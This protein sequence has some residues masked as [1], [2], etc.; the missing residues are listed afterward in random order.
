MNRF[1][2]FWVSVVWTMLAAMTL[3]QFAS[4]DEAKSTNTIR[5]G[6]FPNLSLRTL[7]ETYQPVSDAIRQASKRSVELGS[8]ADFGQ[9][10]QRTMAGEY[11]L[12][13]TAPHLAWLA[14]REAGYR[15]LLS[16]DN[17]VKGIVV[18]RRDSGIK[19]LRELSGKMIAKADPLAIVVIR[20]E[21]SLRSAGLKV[22]ENH[23]ALEAGSHNN[24]AL[25]VLGGKADAA[26]LGILPF[27]KLPT[28]V[29]SQL[30]VIVETDAMPSQVFLV[31]PG[32]SPDQERV[33]QK[34]IEQFMKTAAGRRF[35]AAG[36]FGGVHRLTRTELNRVAQDAK[37][38]RVLLKSKENAVSPATRGAP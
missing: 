34:A 12:V 7:F 30:K 9:F 10:H 6:V 16:Y 14:W 18:V 36:G 26:L 25:Q 29:K 2:S 22:G 15:P 13:L 24:A 17:P 23:T 19:N 8:G 32:V 28:E 20:L 3:I 4:A 5:F 11:D 1:C 21:R 37:Q 35:L 38:I 33:I 31:G 27:N